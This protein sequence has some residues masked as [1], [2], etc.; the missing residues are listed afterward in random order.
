M[1]NLENL[2]EKILQDGSR[3]L[4]QR[5]QLIES[6]A[7]G[8]Y[9]RF[10]RPV[11]SYEYILVMT[12]DGNSRNTFP[13]ASWYLPE[14]QYRKLHEL[15]ND[16]SEFDKVCTALDRFVSTCIKA[17]AEINSLIG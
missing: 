7:Q 9:E 14:R 2:E 3:L 13:F 10:G 1:P 6:V 17:T 15:I 8:M 11:D 12:K 4:L 16:P 5:Y